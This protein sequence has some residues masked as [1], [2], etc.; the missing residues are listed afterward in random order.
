MAQ[1]NHEWK[2]DKYLEC[3]TILGMDLGRWI[4]Q[5]R[6]SA[7]QGER[8]PS[9]QTIA[10]ELWAVTDKGVSHETVRAWWTLW[11]ANTPVGERA[12]R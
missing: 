8:P 10:R 5:W 7:P 6:T 3:E 12:G 11:V 9:W 4:N 2:T 1:P